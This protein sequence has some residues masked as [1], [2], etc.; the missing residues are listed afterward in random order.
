METVD[1]ILLT[2]EEAAQVLNVSRTKVFELLR[3]AELASVKIGGLRRIPAD[4]VAEFVAG[5]RG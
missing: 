3:S 4:A 5:L 2:P 1:K